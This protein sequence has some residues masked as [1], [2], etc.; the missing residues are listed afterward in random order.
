M[1]FDKIQ[2]KIQGPL[3]IIFKGFVQVKYVILEEM[4]ERK[5]EQEA[6]VRK[7]E[8]KNFN[9]TNKVFSLQFFFFGT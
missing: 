9:V 7:I 6:G 4:Q 2:W 8:M 3:K 5:N 1:D